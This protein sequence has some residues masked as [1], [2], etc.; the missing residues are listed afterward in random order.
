MNDDLNIL[1]DTYNDC[2]REP[3]KYLSDYFKGWVDRE[4]PGPNR[5]DRVP[6]GG[7]FRS[8]ALTGYF[9]RCAEAVV[10]RQSANEPEQHVKKL[11]S[12]EKRYG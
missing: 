12:L 11:L 10:S 5:Q 9:I 6:R 2:G 4:V 7:Y 3:S 8:A 1:M